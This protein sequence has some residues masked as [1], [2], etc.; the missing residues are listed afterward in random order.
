MSAD[1]LAR[2]KHEL[3][4]IYGEASCSPYFHPNPKWCKGEFEHFVPFIAYFDIMGWKY[5][6]RARP[7]NQI[8][9]S[10]CS[11]ERP[12][13]VEYPSLYALVADGWRLD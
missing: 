5:V 2:Q 11:E 4:R 8:P 3:E 1:D 12:V 7:G 6:I 13:I 9:T 10:F